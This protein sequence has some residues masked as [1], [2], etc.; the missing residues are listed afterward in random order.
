MP[1][2]EKTQQPHL[3]KTTGTEIR[4]ERRKARPDIEDLTE[5]KEVWKESET[6]PQPK[7]QP[8]SETGRKRVADAGDLQDGEPS[9]YDTE[10]QADRVATQT[11]RNR[12]VTNKKR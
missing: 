1:R 7:P 2:Q 3:S 10:V 8:K 11:D 9:P 4:H 5:P 12:P 6:T